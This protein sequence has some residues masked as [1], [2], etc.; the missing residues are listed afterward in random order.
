M[1]SPGRAALCPGVVCHHR[2]S[3]VTHRFSQRVSMVWIDPDRPEELFGRHWL[4]SS[5]HPAP[6]RFR[7][8]DYGTPDAPVGAAAVRRDL[9]AV[10]VDAD[11]PVRMLTQPRRWGWLFN[12]ITIYLVWADDPALPLGAVVEVTNTPWKECHRYVVPLEAIDGYHVATFDKTLHVS[13]FL[14]VDHRYLLRVRS[15]AS[16]LR[17]EIDVVGRNDTAPTLRTSLAVDRKE[18]TRRGLR[19]FA[20]ANPASAHKVSGGIHLN[21]ARLL[22]HKVPFVGHPKNQDPQHEMSS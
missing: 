7:P 8:E 9:A 15:E 3:P 1:V 18:V 10:G 22:R 6:L 16:R 21:A 5:Q 20:L 2:T 13:P 19:R 11:G 17:V 14:T 4:A 12:P